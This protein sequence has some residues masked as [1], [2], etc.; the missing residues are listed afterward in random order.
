MRLRNIPGARE[1]MLVNPLIV[2]DPARLRGRWHE[3]FGNDR[4]IHIE[5]G[6]GKGQFILTLAQRNPEINYIAIEKYASV[7]L[8]ILTRQEELLLPNLRLIRVNAETVCD[9]FAEGEVDRIYLNFSDPWP[10]DR[11]AKRRL[12]SDRFLS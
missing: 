2:Q 3:E 1:E 6:A 7:L 4:P 5:I 12:T 8:R 10:K 9:I 11:H